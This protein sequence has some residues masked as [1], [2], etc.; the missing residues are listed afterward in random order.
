MMHMTH[1]EGTIG[2]VYEG[3]AGMFRHIVTGELRSPIELQTPFHSMK[4]GPRLRHEALVRRAAYEAYRR[5]AAI[6]D[7]AD[8]AATPDIV[9][10]NH[11]EDFRVVR[12]ELAQD[13]ARKT[14]IL[15][16]RRT[17]SQPSRWR[18][19][20]MACGRTCWALLRLFKAE[21]MYT[22]PRW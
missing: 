17:P 10:C 16:Q 18:P 3:L 13:D 4:D 6:K 7:R 21:M 20:R 19:V 9:E 11:P 22:A 2:Y 15:I 8:R 1:Y 12:P 5:R 14:Y